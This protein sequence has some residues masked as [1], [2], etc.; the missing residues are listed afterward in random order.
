MP[1]TPSSGPEAFF[2]FVLFLNLNKV[3]IEKKSGDSQKS[4]FLIRLDLW[5]AAAGLQPHRVGEC[6]LPAPGATGA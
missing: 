2:C 3:G 4:S 1:R 6:W 5:L